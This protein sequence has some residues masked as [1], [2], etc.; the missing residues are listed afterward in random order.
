M[1]I[2]VEVAI[3]ILNW[4]GKDLLEQFLP[5]VVKFSNKAKIYVADNAS[6]DDSV[7]FVNE[8]FPT[9]RIIQKTMP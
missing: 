1:S 9:V 3:V 4:N 5:S 2:N 8:K 6:E 7:A